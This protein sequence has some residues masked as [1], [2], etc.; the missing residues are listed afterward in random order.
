MKRRLGVLSQTT[1]D[2]VRKKLKS[3]FTAQQGAK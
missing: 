2:A 1:F 3:V